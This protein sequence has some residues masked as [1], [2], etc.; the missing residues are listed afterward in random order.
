IKDG[1]SKIASS[2]TKQG[3]IM[4]MGIPIICNDVGDTGKIIEKSNTGAVVKNFDI[5]NYKQ[6]ISHANELRKISKAHIRQSAFD[7]YDLKMGVEKYGGVYR[8]YFSD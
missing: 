1:Y 2:P 6:V 7:Y 5:E 4:A 3:E 8:D